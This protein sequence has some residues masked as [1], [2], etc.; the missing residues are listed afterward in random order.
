[1]RRAASDDEATPPVVAPPKRQRLRAARERTSR[2]SSTPTRARRRRAALPPHH[3]PPCH[4]GTSSL[5]RARESDRAGISGCG[6]A[7]G[8]STRTRPSSPTLDHARAAMAT[9]D[10]S[11][12]SGA[13]TPAVHALYLGR[14]AGA[15]SFRDWK[16][17]VDMK[18]S[19]GATTTCSTSS[20]TAN[21]AR[22][23]SASSAVNAGDRGAENFAGPDREQS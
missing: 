6:A 11:L 1:M 17:A 3:Y 18:L 14:D 19:I 23:R 5:L 21:A 12:R 22:S 9:H 10:D 15:A 8:E 13:D 2:T 20:P 4:T 16:R 7:Y